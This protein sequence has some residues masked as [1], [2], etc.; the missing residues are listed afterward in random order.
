V[1]DDDGGGRERNAVNEDLP[2]LIAEANAIAND[3]ERTFG[4]LNPEQLNWKRHPDQWSVAQCFEHLIKIDA[5][6]FPQLRRIA[7]GT[8]ASSWRDRVP[9]LA[10]LF[11]SLILRAVQPGSRRQLKAATHVEPA[12]SAIDG[13][14]IARFTAHQREVI[15]HMRA[16]RSHDLSTVVVTS[17][18][19][20]IAFYSALDAFRILVAHERRHLG[21]AERVVNS[22]G[23]PRGERA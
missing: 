21:Q 12:T 16:T 15:E 14:I 6:Y 1:F 18:V 7:Q 17:A 9:W 5:L 3:A 20:P 8:Y 19:A 11:G 22:E 13:D 2:T 4:T 10:H 23:F